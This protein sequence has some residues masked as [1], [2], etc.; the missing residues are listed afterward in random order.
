MGIAGGEA[1]G[2][3]AGEGGYVAA[4]GAGIL[5]PRDTGVQ[6]AQICTLKRCV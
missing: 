3:E 2:G 4:S 5:F 1:R 6:C